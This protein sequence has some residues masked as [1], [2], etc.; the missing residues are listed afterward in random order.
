M[1]NLI[2]AISLF[3]AGTAQASLM[4]VGDKIEFQAN[5]TFVS[6]V[7]SKSLCLNGNT[8]EATIN[9]CVEQRYRGDEEG[10]ECVKF[11]KIQAFQPMKS[12]RQ[13]CAEY[14]GKDDKDCAKWIT[15]PYV[16]KPVRTVKWYRVSN[17]GSDD[18]VKTTTV[19][20]PACK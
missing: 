5:S 17:D 10:F 13:R 15:V 2:L 8:Y 9:K 19:T 16:Q 3:V 1:K 7:F 11:A 18:Y 6:A 4:P 20:I 14:T 12:T